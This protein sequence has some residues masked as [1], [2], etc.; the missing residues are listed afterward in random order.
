MYTYEIAS[1]GGQ[2]G[3]PYDHA[4]DLEAAGHCLGPGAA[5]ARVS[6]EHP[7]LSDDAA[8]CIA[9]L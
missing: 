4:T 2:G 7:P 9:Q 3:G 5:G 6:V 1:V 8:C